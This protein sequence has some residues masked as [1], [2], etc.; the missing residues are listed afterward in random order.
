MQ[1]AVSDANSH[2]N[3]SPTAYLHEQLF[4]RLI[5]LLEDALGLCHSCFSSAD[6]V[7]HAVPHFS[8]LAVFFSLLAA[9]LELQQT[10]SPVCNHSGRSLQG[11]GNGVCGRSALCCCMKQAKT[12]VCW[13]G[14]AAACTVLM[15]RDRNRLHAAGRQ[16]AS[17][18]MMAEVV[19]LAA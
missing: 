15:L 6:G 12:S 14:Y 18:R 8:I 1:L 13:L 16:Q 9:W 7:F 3:M 10:F 11:I 2:T 19:D 17:N 5:K 4:C